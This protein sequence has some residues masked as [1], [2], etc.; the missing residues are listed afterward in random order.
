MAAWD[1]QRV[2]AFKRAFSDFL[3]HVVIFSKDV[4]GETKLELYGSQKRLLTEIFEGLERDIH[5]FVVLKAR[6]QG[7][8]TIV[9][10]LIIFW[11]Y[12]HQGLR[13]ALIYDTEQNKEDARQEIRLILQR[14]PTTHRIGIADG[15]DNRNFIQFANGSRIS[16]LVAGIKKSRGSGGLGRSRGLNCLGATEM[17]SWAD[18]EGL[19]ALERSISRQYPDSLY[20]WESTARGFNIFYDIWDEAKSDELTKK[21]IFIGWWAHP[22]YSFERESALFMRYGSFPPTEDEQQKI[23]LVRD[24]YNHEVTMEQLAWYRHEYDPNIDNPDKEH[25]GQDIIQQELPW[26][27]EE[28]FLKSGASFFSST[29]LTQMTKEALEKKP[30]GYRYFMSEDFLATM[31]EPVKVLR[32][33]HL[34]IWEE[35]DANGV[36]CI[37]ADPAFGSGEG[38]DRHCAQVLRCYADGVDQVAEYCTTEGTTQNFAWVLLHLCGAYGGQ[39]KGARFI[40]ELSGPGNSVRDE[41]KTMQRLLKMGYLR[42]SA[43]E[44]GLTNIMDNVRE[45][46]FTKDDT[47]AQAP[48]AWQWESSSKRKVTIMERLRDYTNVGLIRIRSIDCIKEMET[49]IRDGD[50]IKGD[51]SNK[52]DRVIAL[53]LAAKAW[54]DFERKTMVSQKRTR[55][56]EEKQ[57]SFTS[58]DLQKMFSESIFQGFIH[59]NQRSR[60]MER[61]AAR[62]G[63]RWNF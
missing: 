51:G 23:D 37:G 9:R 43:Q 10:V 21:A 7:I 57:R 44:H 30:Q 52:D 4:V 28:A 63:N 16:F 47:I 35:P 31:V 2:Q 38:A 50:I 62:R 61:R 24:R 19:R 18:I 12:M 46:L 40:L 26:F 6:Q 48:T 20:I 33:A 22:G 56:F 53:A 60:M 29:K 17:S 25:A 36:Y 55:D 5:S 32:H 1:K 11:S 15:G 13:V 27:E 41:I 58:G 45:F 59:Q 42:A 14:L 34:K 8:S 39:T 49:V 54:A 3:G